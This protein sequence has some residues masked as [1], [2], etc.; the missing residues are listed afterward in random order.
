MKNTIIE[1][2]HQLI[3]E[4]LNKM[5]DSL[6]L[7]ETAKLALND[8]NVIL[9]TEFKL[10]YQFQEIEKAILKDSDFTNAEALA[11]LRGIKQS[12]SFLKTYQLPHY[13]DLKTTQIKD[14]VIKEIEEQYTYRLNDAQEIIFQNLNNA[15]EILNNCGVVA[16]LRYL[17]T[18][19][20]GIISVNVNALNQIR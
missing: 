10:N 18:A 16:P 2:D 17:N 6:P 7:V 15:V 9:K 1:I 3:K 11:D 14:S 20:D 8:I 4:E 12:F 13:I 5:A 19:Y